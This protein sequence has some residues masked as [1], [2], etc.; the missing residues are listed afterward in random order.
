MR[1]NRRFLNENAGNADDALLNAASRGDAA[2]VED[3]LKRGAD[4]EAV[5]DLGE[6]ALQVAACNGGESAR[7]VELLIKAGADVNRRNIYG[8]TALI[9][10]ARSGDAASLKRLIAAGAELDVRSRSTNSDGGT[11][12]GAAALR[13]HSRCVEILLNAGADPNIADKS[14]AYPI[15]Y[16]LRSARSVKALVKAGGT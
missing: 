11:A 7:C 13:N 9:D 4:P 10:A 3:A 5:D 1:R 8:E 12:L 6:T 16:A 14:G 2:G 15:E